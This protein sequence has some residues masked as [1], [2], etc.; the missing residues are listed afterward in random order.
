MREPL[1][2]RPKGANRKSLLIKLD[3]APGD[4]PAAGEWSADDDML[5]LLAQIVFALRPEVVVSCGSGLPL[6]VIARALD[7]IG[8]GHVTAIDHD[9]GAVE[10]VERRL[11]GLSLDRRAS[12]HHACLGEYDPHTAWYEREVLTELP[13]EIDFL[14]VDG[15][16]IF[17]GRTPRAPAG[18]ELFPRLTRDGVVLLDDGKRAKEKKT[19]RIW[20]ETFP[21]LE[22]TKLKTERNAVMLRR[23]GNT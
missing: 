23:G 9:E 8:S 18:P 5:N 6:L 4:L 11:A 3:L 10:D 17:A 15:P 14:F 13:G 21:H 1:P 12:V 19:L 7:L 22:Q 16:P 2:T 20:A